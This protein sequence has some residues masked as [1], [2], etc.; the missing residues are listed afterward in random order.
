MNEH[1][2]KIADATQ[3]LE[4]T[5]RDLETAREAVTVA[6]SAVGAAIAKGDN[7]EAAS[8]ALREARERVE[9]HTAA[10]PHLEAA[11]AKARLDQMHAER[12]ARGQQLREIAEEQIAVTEELEL[13]AAELVKLLERSV[14]LHDRGTPLAR[15]NGLGTSRYRDAHEQRDV[16]RRWIAHRLAFALP[17][18]FETFDYFKMPLPRIERERLEEVL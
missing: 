16:L 2:K 7:P 11:V 12:D 14:K 18:A 15:A 13:T 3:R 17:G 6:T 5:R 8:A 4:G 1:Q 10:L 9:D